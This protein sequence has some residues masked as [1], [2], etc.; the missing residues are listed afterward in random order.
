MRGS[1]EKPIFYERRAKGWRESR[2]N[3]RREWHSFHVRARPTR[4]KGQHK[5][6]KN[7]GGNL[8]RRA[9]KVEEPVI[10]RPE[11]EGQGDWLYTCIGC[12]YQLKARV[13]FNQPCPKC[14]GHRWMCHWLEMPRPTIKKSDN[15]TP[16]QH[17]NNG[18]HRNKTPDPIKRRTNI[19]L[20]L[21]HKPRGL[22][23][24]L[25]RRETILP[26]DLINQLADQGLGCKA[27]AIKLREQ[28][29]NIS[30]MT[31]Q[32]RLKTREN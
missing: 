15:E 2:T 26:T 25:G 17:N 13:D 5:R 21:N 24:V 18:T 6:E 29:I 10:E 12:G 19:L 14:G 7:E 9:K 23:P 3:S 4:G 31:I 22:T 27:I 30:H 1:G 20:P 28:G 16:S 11:P 8:V 32:R